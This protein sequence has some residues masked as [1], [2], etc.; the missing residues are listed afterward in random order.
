M[1]ALLQELNPC[2][3]C[4]RGSCRK[5]SSHLLAAAA[6]KVSPDM[7]ITLRN[8]RY[9]RSEFCKVATFVCLAVDIYKRSRR[10][11]SNLT[12]VHAPL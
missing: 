12:L 8:Q 9:R 2:H 10:V 4:F 7:Q 11:H 3:A 6:F 5:A 1:Y